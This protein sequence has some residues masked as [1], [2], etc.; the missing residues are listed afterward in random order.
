MDRVASFLQPIH[1]DS[2]ESSL[3]GSCDNQR[4]RKLLESLHVIALIDLATGT[5]NAKLLF[6]GQGNLRRQHGNKALC[7]GESGEFN[8]SAVATAP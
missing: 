4:F 1:H 8:P 5:F 3:P 7:W 6:D 2:R